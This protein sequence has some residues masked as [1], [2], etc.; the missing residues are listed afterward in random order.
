MTEII[1]SEPP[2]ESITA[3]TILYVLAIFELFFAGLVVAGLILGWPATW[4]SLWIGAAFFGMA[5][6]VDIYRK[7]FLPDEMVTKARLPKVIPR[8]E[9]KE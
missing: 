6:M 3:L 8:R 1:R 5:G 7:N 9:L 2:T 4:L